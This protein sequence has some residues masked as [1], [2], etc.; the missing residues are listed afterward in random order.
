MKFVRIKIC[1]I[2][3]STR[4]IAKVNHPRQ[5]KKNIVESNTKNDERKNKETTKKRISR[6]LTRNIIPSSIF[7]RRKESYRP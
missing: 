2:L 6:R 5:P 3:S 1:K 7:T 4:F